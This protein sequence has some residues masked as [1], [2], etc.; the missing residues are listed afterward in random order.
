[1]GN[2]GFIAS[3][4]IPE[5]SISQEAHLGYDC[6]G[7]VDNVA[8][9]EVVKQKKAPRRKLSPRRFLSRLE[10]STQFKPVLATS[11]DNRFLD[12]DIGTD[13]RLDLRKVYAHRRGVFTGEAQ[14][15]KSL[16]ESRQ[17][18]LSRLERIGL[19]VGYSFT[20]QTEGMPE[21]H[22]V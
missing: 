2:S 7:S 4:P 13:V 9:C 20:V 16:L 18:G 6:T 3:K 15:P 12:L 11:L 17:S 19:L 14:Q 10:T 22:L 21:I 8:N 5:W 1:M